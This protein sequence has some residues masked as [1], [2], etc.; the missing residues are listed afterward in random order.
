[1]AKRKSKSWLFKLLLIMAICL[2]PGIV[3]RWVIGQSI[4]AKMPQLIGPA[5]SNSASVSGS[6]I[7]ILQGKI[8]KVN[9]HSN[10]VKLSS[11]VTV[12]SLDVG[13]M[14]VRFKPDKTVTEIQS[15][16]FTAS[17]SEDSLEKY[18]AAS[19]PDMANAKVTLSEDKLT[20]SA[21]PRMLATRTPVTVE[22]TLRII[23]RT[24]L[25]LVV[26]KIRARGMRVPG[27]MRGRVM[28]D[29]NPVLDTQKLGIGG[30]F[31]SV[32]I[33]CGKIDLTGTADVRQALK[34]R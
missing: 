31:T 34:S 17:V 26:N 6:S 21:S 25:Y 2:A 32:K 23:D 27:F 24:K 4:A 15:T 33:S 22:G 14:G 10:K 7:D 19:Q 29:I 3:L 8:A 9:L 12:D 13:L 18:I 30:E 28:R 20:I 1:M 5:Q 16:N 11:G